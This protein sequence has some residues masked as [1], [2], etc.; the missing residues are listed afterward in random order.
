MVLN[1][2]ILLFLFL[3]IF[4]ISF[5]SA[6]ETSLGTFPKG[7][8]IELLQICSNETS[9]CDGCNISSVKYPNSSILIS[10]VE[11]TKR[12][13]DFNYTLNNTQ[14]NTL[15]VHLVNGFCITSS[16]VEVFSYTFQITPDGSP[17]ITQ[18]ESLILIGAIVTILIMAMFFL[19]ISIIAKSSPVKVFFISLAALMSVGTIAFMLASLQQLL[20]TFSTLLTG[21]KVFYILGIALLTAGGMAL[22]LYLIVIAFVSFKKSRGLFDSDV[23]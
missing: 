8:Q 13:A 2:K 21:Y 5:I 17:K 12:A 16:Q 1:K 18:G 19:I 3:G 11:M 4:L 14:S 15:G 9:L 20:G 6:Q 23:D 10:N 7:E 22:M